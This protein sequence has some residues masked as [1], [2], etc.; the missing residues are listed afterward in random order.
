MDEKSEISEKVFNSE[1]LIEKW[2]K[3]KAL[4]VKKMSKTQGVV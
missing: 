3:I 2:E 1:K 4:E